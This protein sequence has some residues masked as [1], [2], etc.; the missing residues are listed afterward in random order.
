MLTVK[1][2]AEAAGVR[3]ETVYAWLRDGILVSKRAGK[4]G[5]HR[6]SRESLLLIGVKESDIEK[7]EKKVRNEH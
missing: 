1:I 5:R 4:H 2:A 7:A 3:V 6:I